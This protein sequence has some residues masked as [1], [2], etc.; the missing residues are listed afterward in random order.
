MHTSSQ[1]PYLFSALLVL[2]F[3]VPAA[4][5][6]DT[7]PQEEEAEATSEQ[8]RLNEQAVEAMVAGNPGRAVALLTE[9]QRLGELNILALN[10]GRAYHAA[11][12]CARARQVLES[13]PELPAVER[14]APERVNERA[15]EYLADVEDTCEDE[16]E[17]AVDVDEEDQPAVEE[18][19]VEEPPAVDDDASNLKQIGLYTAISGGV[20]LLAGGGMHTAAR[21][22]RADALDRINDDGS[23]ENGVNTA[24]TQAEVQSIE[25]RANTLDTV[26]LSSAIIGGTALIMGGY[27]FFSSDTVADEEPNLSFNLG[28]QSWSVNWSV[29]F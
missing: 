29:R 25:A 7:P 12:N 28:Q 27:L 13:V 8:L 23:F 14:P 10:L 11:G 24:I 26:A 19:A 2:F 1:L 4:V 15:A 21:M 22:Q 6:A 3:L 5:L 16:V 20:L 18:R 9:A 17:V